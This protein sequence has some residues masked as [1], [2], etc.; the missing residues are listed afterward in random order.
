M[1]YETEKH[2]ANIYIYTVTKVIS[3]DN[4]LAQLPPNSRSQFGHNYVVTL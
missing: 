3:S 1:K 4:R 2:T